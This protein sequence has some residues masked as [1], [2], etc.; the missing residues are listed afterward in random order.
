M[1]AAASAL[2]CLDWPQ[3]LITTTSTRR[4]TVIGTCRRRL[5]KLVTKW[6]VADA[7][8]AKTLTQARG[9]VVT[10]GDVN[11]DDHRDAYPFEPEVVRSIDGYGGLPLFSRLFTSRRPGIESRVSATGDRRRGRR[12]G[13]QGHS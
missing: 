12:R 5:R 8:V 9:L 6:L 1:N 10:V 4:S 7:S 11:G 13:R 2:G 3:K